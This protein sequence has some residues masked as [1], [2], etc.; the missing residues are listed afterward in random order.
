M[1][2]IIQVTTEE[3]FKDQ[4]EVLGTVVVKISTSTCGPCKMMGPVFDKLSQEDF[5]YSPTFVS[6]VADST[7]ELSSL[8]Q[9][10]GVQSVPVF[11]VYQDSALINT[12]VGA[13]PFSTLKTKLDL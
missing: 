2:N 5:G 13:F 11:L 3:E 1:S 10:L 9:S 4:I 6:M 12:V 7:P 8:A